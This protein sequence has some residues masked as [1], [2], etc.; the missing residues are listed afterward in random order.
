MTKRMDQMSGDII[1]FWFETDG[2]FR[3]EWFT[4]TREL[5]DQ[6]TARF[7]DRLALIILF[8]QFPRHIHRNRPKSFHYDGLA[9]RLLKEASL[10][11][12]C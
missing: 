10:L 1:E 2:A 6:V 5:D 11:E 3:A 7:A 9:L 4:G 8:D 12:S